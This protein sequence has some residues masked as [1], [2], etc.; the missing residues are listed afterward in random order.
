MPAST[1]KRSNKLSAK[2][3]KKFNTCKDLIKS[4]LAT[5]PSVPS[6]LQV[7]GG[8]FNHRN[9]LADSD[10]DISEFESEEEEC[11]SETIHPKKMAMNTDVN[12]GSPL[13][14]EG[15]IKL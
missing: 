14:L 3:M 9:I 2:L 12:S 15:E 7:L 11:C 1:R 4:D 10:S 8:T 13:L 5:S 6:R